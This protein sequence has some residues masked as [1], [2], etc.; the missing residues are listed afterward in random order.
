MLHKVIHLKDHFPFLGEDGKDPTLTAYVPE[1][2]HEMDWSD[3]KHPSILVCPG[4]GYAYVS[5]REA[6]PIAINVLSWGYNAFVLN[7][8]CAPHSFP[9]QL[10]EVAA[11]MELIHENANEWHVDTDRIAIMGFSAGGHLAAHYS[12]CYDIPEV[13]AVFPDSKPVRASVLGYPVITADPAHRHEDTFLNL[14]G[15]EVISPEDVENFSLEKKVTDRTPPAFIWHT[16]EDACVPVMNSILYAQALAAYKKFFAV[17]IYSFGYHGL[18][19]ADGL[20]CWP[21][22][23]AQKA[24]HNWLRDAKDW[25]NATFY[26]L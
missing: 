24:T 14:T 22:D 3:K 6:E 18:S 15:H 9:T 26:D 20:A 11:A 23:E 2:M 19:T 8:S 7:Y 12:N 1:N 13:R 17:H 25:L 10:L 4:G 16:A 21:L 5:A